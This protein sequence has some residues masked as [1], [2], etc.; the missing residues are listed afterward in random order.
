MK[1]YGRLLLTLATSPFKDRIDPLATAVSSWTVLPNDLDLFGH[2]NNGRYAMVMDLA[3]VDFVARLGLM[4]ELF[5]KRWIVP[6]GSTRIEF[7]K[8]L[9]PFTR[10][11]IHTRLC[12]WDD[13]WFYFRQDF[14]IPAKTPAGSPVLAASAYVKAVFQDGRGT[15]PSQHIVDAVM[16]MQATRAERP[17]LTSEL[18]RQFDLPF[19]VGQTLPAASGQR[20]TSADRL[21][22]SRRS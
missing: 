22:P 2:M 3:R 13:A 1:L 20:G 4:G 12:Y 11:E 15:V 17:A 7:R 10:Y 21:A 14:M 8:A 6:V 5:R 19:K 16:S 9:K 18:A